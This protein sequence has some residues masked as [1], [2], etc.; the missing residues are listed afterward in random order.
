MN[1]EFV[2][3]DNVTMCV[4]YIQGLM[5]TLCVKGDRCKCEYV[6]DE[7]VSEVYAYEGLGTCVN[8]WDWIC[9]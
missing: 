5:N 1:W 8:K 6:Y 7:G 3:M 9:M 2:N 4:I